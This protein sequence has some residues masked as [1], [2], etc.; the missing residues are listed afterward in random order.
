M[1]CPDCQ[2]RIAADEWNDPA[3]AGHLAA[4]AE[5]RE[6]S[7]E[8]AENAAALRSLDLDAAAYTAVRARVMEAVR[9]RRRFGWIWAPASAALMACVALI[10]LTVTPPL[11]T[12]EPP[13]PLAVVHPVHVEPPVIA[14]PVAVVNKKKPVRKPAPLQAIKILTDDP[15]VVIIWLVDDK[16]GD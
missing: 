13:R 6:F 1:N 12:P 15:N 11:R 4:C 16:K 9:P 7:Y 10:W 8:L 5:C 2:I 14:R 3:V